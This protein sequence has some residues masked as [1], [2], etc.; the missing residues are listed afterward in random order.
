V[1]GTSDTSKK[2]ADFGSRQTHVMYWLDEERRDEVKK[3]RPDALLFINPFNGWAVTYKN[4]TP[5]FN[6]KRVRQAAALLLNRKQIIDGVYKGEGEDD[7]WFSWAIK[8]PVG[9]FSKPAQLA[10]ARLWKNDPQ[11]AKQLL[12]AAGITSPIE[13]VNHHWDATVV[14]QGVVDLN[15]LISTQWRTAGFINSK[16][17]T[18]TFPQYASTI[19]I[20]NFEGWHAGPSGAA[21]TDPAFGNGWRNAIWS[22]PEG[23]KGPSTN[24]AHTNDPKA[25]EL[26]DKQMGQFVVAERRETYKQLEDIFSEEMYRL[27]LNQYTNNWFTDQ[28]LQGHQIPVTNVN[29]SVHYVKYWWFKDGKAP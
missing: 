24:N 1:L 14:G 29:G 13:M 8:T 28:N 27:P 11:T 3:L 22:P 17:N 21:L 6:D 16:D 10:G 25:S 2:I 20:G 23:I 26:A 7:Q 9:N 4:D 19:A 12:S 18:L 5:P 15:T